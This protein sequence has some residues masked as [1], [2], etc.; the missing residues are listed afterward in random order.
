MSCR[1]GRHGQQ[2]GNSDARLKRELDLS[3]R[4]FWRHGKKMTT[5]PRNF[6]YGGHEDES[7]YFGS[8]LRKLRALRGVGP[9][10]RIKPVF[11]YGV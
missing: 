2:K 9:A 4:T 6:R 8:Y 3:Q 1:K 10:I 7:K 5:P 11:S